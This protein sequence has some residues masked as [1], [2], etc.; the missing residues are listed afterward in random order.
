[1]IEVG[2]TNRTALGDYEQALA[3]ADIE[4]GA[5]LR[6]HQSNFRT[7]GFVEEVAVDSLCQFGVPV[8]DDVG[9]GVLVDASG[10]PAL[11]PEPAI[12]ESIA[13]GAA[14]VCCS[15]DKL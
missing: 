2:T 1:M 5:I 4:V 3:H 12:R 6:V 7:L 14:L 13:A 10:M 15:G 11:A 9:S 8:I